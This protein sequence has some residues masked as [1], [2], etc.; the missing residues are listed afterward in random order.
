MGLDRRQDPARVG[1]VKTE[2]L[3]RYEAELRSVK[4]AFGSADLAIELAPFKIAPAKPLTPRPLPPDSLQASPA[5]RCLGG[6]PP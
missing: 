5:R 1:A 2:D 6:R 4:A 3:L